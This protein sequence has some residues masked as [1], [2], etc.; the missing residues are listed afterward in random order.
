MIRRCAAAGLPEPEFAVT[1][2]FVTTIR[3]A[4]SAARDAGQAVA[5]ATQET[6]GATQE[7]RQITQEVT[8]QR[9]LDLLEAEPEITRRRLAERLGIT[10]D[11]VKYHLDK[12][13][14]AG[15]I[16]HVGPTKA[17]RWE[18]LK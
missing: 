11:G 13:R 14:N 2:G 5:G 1:D 16:R 10:P 12:L 4:T 8:R 9:V 17:G 7:D 18:V 15:I 3:R 6:G